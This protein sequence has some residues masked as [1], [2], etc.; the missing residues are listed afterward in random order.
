MAVFTYMAQLMTA[1]SFLYTTTYP[2]P[3]PQDQE[4]NH[5]ISAGN[6]FEVSEDDHS[7]YYNYGYDSGEEAGT[8]YQYNY[9]AIFTDGGE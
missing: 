7:Y 4:P 1:I 5:W 3:V 2:L 8:D 6:D 9:D